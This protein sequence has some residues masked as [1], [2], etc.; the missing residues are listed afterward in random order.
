LG[1][2]AGF[3]P[4]IMLGGFLVFL[5][6]AIKVLWKMIVAAKQKNVYWMYQQMGPVMGVGFL[7]IVIGCILSRAEL[8]AAFANIGPASVVFFAFWFFGMS[9]MG[10]FA[11]KLDSSDP[12]SNW[13]EQGTNGVAELCLCI[14][15][16]LL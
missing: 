12:K 14:A 9:L 8:K 3:S 1:M 7:L 6:G 2:K 15:L 13:I 11:K 10:F 4:L 16:A 5:G